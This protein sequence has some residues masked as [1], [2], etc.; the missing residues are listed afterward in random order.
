MMTNLKSVI[1]K[2][3]T[4]VNAQTQI[5]QHYSTPP[6]S[7]HKNTKALNKAIKK[8]EK[9]LMSHKSHASS[10]AHTA[11]EHKIEPPKLH[12][13]MRLICDVFRITE[14]S[15]YALRTFDATNLDDFSLMTD[16]DYID[17]I[18]TRARLGCPLP[19]LQQRKLNVLR[20]WVQS[21]PVSETAVA[22][23]ESEGFEVKESTSSGEDNVKSYRNSVRK[24]V[25]RHTPSDWEDRFYKDL[26]RL[27]KELREAGKGDSNYVFEYLG[28]RWLFCQ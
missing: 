1:K 12:R 11:E 4:T 5:Q 10:S 3:E 22:P 15:R 13:D 19:P 28:L 9:E 2:K 26:P 18:A 14:E 7:N 17:L 21:L 25:G 8:K 23:V 16:S 20:R 6:P 24:D 27:R